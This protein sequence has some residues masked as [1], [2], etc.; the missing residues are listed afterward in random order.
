M[1]KIYFSYAILKKTCLNYIIQG[2][3]FEYKMINDFSSNSTLLQYFET[4][5]VL[6]NYFVCTQGGHCNVTNNLKIICYI[7]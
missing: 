6:K 1:Q 5:P 2:L 4:H 7:K 3:H